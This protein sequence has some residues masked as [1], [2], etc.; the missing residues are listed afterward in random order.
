MILLGVAVLAQNEKVVEN[1]PKNYLKALKSDNE[2]AME[3]A[4]FH[5]VKFKLFYP[6]EDTEALSNE[7]GQIAKEGKTKAI[8]YKAYLASQ[9]MNDAE[10]LEKIEQRDYKD[11]NVFF[12]QLADELHNDMLVER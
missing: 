11:A 3:S 10:L 5:S 2:G 12:K 9:F 7:L 4:I 6:E 1:A 8:R